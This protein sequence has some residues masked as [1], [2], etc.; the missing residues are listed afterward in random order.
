MDPAE[1]VIARLAVAA[2]GLLLLACGGAA[3]ASPPPPTREPPAEEPEAGPD[4]AE[5]RPPGCRLAVRAEPAQRV[6]HTLRYQAGPLELRF[7]AATVEP[8][9]ERH[10]AEVYLEELAAEA[11]GEISHQPFVLGGAE[12]LQITIRAPGKRVRALTLW[13]D[14]A[15][16]RLIVV[17]HPRDAGSAERV[18]ESLRFDPTIPLDPEAALEV[19]VD[20]VEGLPL[21]PV[22]TEQ[23][24]F[25]EAGEPGTF[26]SPRATMDV[27]YLRFGEE[28]PDQR[29]RG[30][31]LGR[32]FRGIPMGTPTVEVIEGAHFG[33]F[34]M[35][36]LTHADGT[37]LALLGAY[38]ELPDGALLVRAS[39]A[40]NRADEWTPRFVALIRSLRQASSLP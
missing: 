40:A 2:A 11:P 32:R 33:G 28:R 13:R 38:L 26:P 36:A 17:H 5:L 31:L 19:A 34:A 20:E 3:P 10:V 15:I 7:A 12:G 27:A 35:Q 25:R 9:Q 30:R 39:V 1:T 29:E 6:P 18:I 23:M 16:S 22:S 8:G 14:G 21:L 4:L 24:Y 37:Q